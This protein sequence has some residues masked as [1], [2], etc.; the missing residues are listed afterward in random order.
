MS[1]NKNELFDMLED[2]FPK[3]MSS[4]EL[5]KAKRNNYGIT[6]EEVAKATG[7]SQSNLS[8]Y[9]NDK[10]GLGY[11]QA[12]KIGLAVGLHPMT[13]LFP[14]G[15]D[16]DER[17]KEVSRKSEKLISKKIPLKKIA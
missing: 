14:N 8:L 15:I 9:E 13:I 16:A 1:K 3:K 5:I 17:F 10:K 7:I 11:V 12:T 2:F 4:G 6:L